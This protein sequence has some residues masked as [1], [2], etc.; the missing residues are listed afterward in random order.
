VWSTDTNGLLLFLIEIG[1]VPRLSV[2]VKVDS[3]SDTFVKPVISELP[4]KKLARVSES[5][6]AYAMNSGDGVLCLSICF[7]GMTLDLNGDLYGLVEVRTV[8]AG[9]YPFS[10]IPKLDCTLVWKFVCVRY[11]AVL[12]IERVIETE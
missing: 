8:W 3:C 12:A 11:V 7:D 2:K 10:V 6:L 5:S 9:S 4:G 1:T